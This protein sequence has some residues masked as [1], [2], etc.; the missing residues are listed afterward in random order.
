[1]KCLQ[2]VRFTDKDLLYLMVWRKMRSNSPCREKYFSTVRCGRIAKKIALT[3]KSGDE[4]RTT[5]ENVILI[6]FAKRDIWY[7]AH[8]TEQFSLSYENSVLSVNASWDLA[9]EQDPPRM[10]I[11]QKSVELD[12]SILL[13]S[14]MLIEVQ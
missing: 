10:T 6:F 2:F 4:F 11:T 8:G 9:Q 12:I 1:M 14:K 13:K 7:L 3:L 5:F